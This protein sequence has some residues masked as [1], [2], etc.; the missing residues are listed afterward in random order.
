MSETN[1]TP[2]AEPPVT[3][4]TTQVTTTSPAPPPWHQL[5]EPQ[6]II[7]V[8]LIV[9]AFIIVVATIRFG[10]ENLQSQVLLL[11]SSIVTGLMGFFFG[12]AI[13]KATVAA[14]A[15]A[16]KTITTTTTP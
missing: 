5:M 1:Q 13:G 7:S 2:P 8:L 12:A 4:V 3:Q 11:A 10:S 15:P 9:L 6:F 16:P 14:S